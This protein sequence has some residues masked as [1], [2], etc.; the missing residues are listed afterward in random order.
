[1]KW[2][3]VGL[4]L[5]TIP[6]IT[7]CATIKGASIGEQRQYVQDMK[8][9]TLK[10]L[11]AT[12]PEAKRQIHKSAGYGVFSNIGMN[13]F[14]LSTGNG[15]GVVTDK[16][17][18]FD[19]DTYMKMGTVGVGI[20]MGVKDFRQVIIFRKHG[21]LMRFLEKGWSFQGQADAA[22]KS[23][24]K[25]AAGSK[26]QSSNLDVV[27]YQL[28]ANGIALQATIQGVKYWKHPDLN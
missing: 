23:G 28:T 22:A 6:F 4:I 3:Q 24:D 13:V 19:Q 2:T 27:T 8:N 12:H 11:Y 1:M 17:K 5:I 9:Q 10:E 14:L 21:D 15:F 7:S 20:G 16:W 25:G 18:I 26:A